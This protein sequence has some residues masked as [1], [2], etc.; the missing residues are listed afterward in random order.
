[1]FHYLHNLLISLTLEEKQKNEN[2]T[3]MGLIQQ[4]TASHHNITEFAFSYLW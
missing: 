1:M 2:E 3:K 4:T